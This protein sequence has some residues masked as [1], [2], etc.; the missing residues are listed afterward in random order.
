[1]VS[2]KDRIQSYEVKVD[3]NPYRKIR[4]KTRT[5]RSH[6]LSS[7][8]WDVFRVIQTQNSK[9]EFLEQWLMAPAS[10]LVLM[11]GVPAEDAVRGGKWPFAH[12]DI[13]GTPR[14]LYLLKEFINDGTFVFLGDE[15]QDRF[16]SESK[17][18]A[19]E[20]AAIAAIH[21]PEV[22][23]EEKPAKP[24]G[25]KPPKAEVAVEEKPEVIPEV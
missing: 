21:S 24:K 25:P 20:I 17:K 6:E 2:A 5:S 7:Q 3:S 23:V 18:Y 8:G 4:V 19:K 10:C 13:V 16:D 11:A 9:G 1:M 22:A 14:N 12:G 15:S